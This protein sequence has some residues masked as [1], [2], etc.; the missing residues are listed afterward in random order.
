MQNK[1]EEKDA[2]E[3]LRAAVKALL[4]ASELCEA[5]GYGS[6]VLGPLAD[7]QREAN[8]ALDTA[9]GRN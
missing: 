3:A 8:Y 6:Q 9:L 2:Q 1:V 4:R 7:A 5:V